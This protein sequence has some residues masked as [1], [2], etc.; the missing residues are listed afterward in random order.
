MEVIQGFDI[1]QVVGNVW[2]VVLGF[3]LFDVVTGLLAAAIEKKLNSSI[4]Y[5][6]LIRKVGE[7]TAL[8]FLIFIDAYTGSNGNIIKIGVGMIVA[9]E[10]LSIIE[11]FSRMGINISWLTK[12]FD[13]DKVGKS[14]DDK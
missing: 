5:I 2:Y 6:G 10:G 14:G 8:A 12:Y 11:N 3:I 7:F 9:Y 1:T 13:Q 4:N